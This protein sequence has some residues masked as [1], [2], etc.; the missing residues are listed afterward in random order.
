MDRLLT[1][2]EACER[3]R[4]SRSKLGRLVRDRRLIPVR[5]GRA[6]RFHP[7]DLDALIG[8]ARSAADP[9]AAGPRAGVG[10]AR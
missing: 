4:L 5:F 10:A 3:L 8:A 2:A 9:D 6:V 7:G 1:V